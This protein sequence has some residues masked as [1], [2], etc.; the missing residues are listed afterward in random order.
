MCNKKLERGRY[1]QETH[2]Y[3]A[4]QLNPPYDVGMDKLLCFC[5]LLP[6]WM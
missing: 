2:L 3:L 5:Y 1:K 6:L 4:T